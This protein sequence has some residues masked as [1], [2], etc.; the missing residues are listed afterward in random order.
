M[1]FLFIFFFFKGAG[2]AEPLLA[3]NHCKIPNIYWKYWNCFENLEFLIPPVGRE[4]WW[5][6]NWRQQ[7]WRRQECREVSMAVLTC[8]MVC[9]HTAAAAVGEEKMGP[10]KQPWLNWKPAGLCPRHLIAWFWGALLFVFF[11]CVKEEKKAWPLLRLAHSNTLGQIL[12]T[13]ARERPWTNRPRAE[14]TREKSNASYSAQ[15]NLS[16]VLAITFCGTYTITITTAFFSKRDTYSVSLFS[17]H[18]NDTIYKFS[19]EFLNCI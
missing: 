11:C 1:S 16:S 12:D 4:T 5:V 13:H 14:S 2:G 7:W 8:A 15:T 17:F 18:W 10:A 6:K 9:P 3:M 19:F